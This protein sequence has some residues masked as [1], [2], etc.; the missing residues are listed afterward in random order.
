[1]SVTGAG[2][3]ELADLPL[4][5]IDDGTSILLTGD[6]TDLLETVFY[7]LLS[8][9][10]DEGSLVLATDASGR[11]V[12]RA[13][14]RT[15]DGASDRST[16]LTC[17]GPDSPEN[18]TT[19]DDITDLTGIGM[20][21]SSLV[22]ESQETA[23]RL[24]AGIILC[25]SICSAVD[26]TR[27]VFRF[28]NSNLLSQVRRNEAIGI[29]A[30]DTSADIGTSMKSII[31]GMSTSFTGRIEVESDGPGRATLHV[32]GLGDDETYD[33]SL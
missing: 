13:L 30:L 10:D 4:G 24:R 22:A 5:P 29:C 9:Q 6:D 16:V 25:S 33:V 12:N 3:F 19:I 11:E 26:D 31:A 27:S 2:P 7:R 32:T 21:F 28:L 18:V 17:T 8:S 20:Q 14:E 1:M 15:V 23:S